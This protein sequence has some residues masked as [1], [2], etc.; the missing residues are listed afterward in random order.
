MHLNIQLLNGR[1]YNVRLVRY[2]NSKTYLRFTIGSRRSYQ[3][4]GDYKTN[5]RLCECYIERLTNYILHM[6]EKNNKTLFYIEGECYDESWQ[7]KDG[8][9]KN[10]SCTRVK[11]VEV[12]GTPIYDNGKT[13]ESDDIE[14]DVGW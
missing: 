12:I 7:E 3:E 6:Y 13:E 14:A 8:S 10:K 2:A 9:W 5:F 1:I 11:R 4:N